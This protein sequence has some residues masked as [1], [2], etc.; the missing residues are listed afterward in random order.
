MKEDIITLNHN[1][2]KRQFELL[3]FIAS[4]LDG[5]IISMDNDSGFIKKEVDV[6]TTDSF[7]ISPIFFPGGD[8]GKL[9]ICGSINDVVMVGAEPRYITLSFIFEEGFSLVDLSRIL[10]SIK[11]ELDENNLSIISG[12]TKVMEKNALDRI[13]I[14]TTC[15]GKIIGDSMN[16]AN[17]SKGDSIIITDPIGFHG[18]AVMASRKGFEIDFTS[19]CRSLKKLLY[20]SNSHKI[21]AMRDPTRGG[22][23]QIL[24]ELALSSGFDIL[25]RGNDIPIPEGVGGIAEILGIN[26]LY[27]P[28]EGNAV[29]FCDKVDLPELTTGLTKGGFNPST[30]GEVLEK[31]EKPRLILKTGLGNER[32]L[33]MLVEELTPRIC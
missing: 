22:L 2:G 1:S 27:L 33:P 10:S 5:R 12:D 19:D 15:L 17:I 21:H 24:N 11:R 31:S 9:S 16:T 13:V 14:N 7:T 20:I 25:I 23:A 18:S 26:P 28:N 4:G 30:I 6:I 8:I 29:I 3:K 32:I